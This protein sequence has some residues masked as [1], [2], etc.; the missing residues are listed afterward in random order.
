MRGNRRRKRDN[1]TRMALILVA[2]VMLSCLW[3]MIT[4]WHR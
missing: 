2:M 3:E 1:E 4:L